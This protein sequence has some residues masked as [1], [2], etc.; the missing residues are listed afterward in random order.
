[1]KT[2][3]KLALAR[4]LLAIAGIARVTTPTPQNATAATPP[5][6]KVESRFEAKNPVIV[7]MTGRADTLTVTST[8]HGPAYSVNTLTGESLLAAGSLDDLRRVRPDLYDHV[9]SGVAAT[10]ESAPLLDA[11]IHLGGLAG[12]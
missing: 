9:R 6:P 1:M 12:E 5:T 4:P 11:S 3:T 7:R 8:P 2:R 10:D